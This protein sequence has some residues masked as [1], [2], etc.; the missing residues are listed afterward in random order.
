MGIVRFKVVCE[1]AGAKNVDRDSV[2][3]QVPLKCMVL[4]MSYRTDRL[5]KAGV[6]Q[7][8]PAPAASHLEL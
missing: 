7:P 2:V 3:S 6:S 4:P 5:M 1:A 8:N